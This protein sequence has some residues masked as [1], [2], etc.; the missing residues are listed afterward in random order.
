MTTA[1]TTG[2]TTSTT[3]Q[4]EQWLGNVVKDI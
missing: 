3:D 2:M 4:I 1:M